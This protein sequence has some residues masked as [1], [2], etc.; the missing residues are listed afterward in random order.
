MEVSDRVMAVV[1]VFE[2]HVLKFTCGY[3][4]RSGSNFEEKQFFI[5]SWKVSA[6]C[7]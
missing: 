7:R 5:M 3:A 6:Y 4:K 2:E 1:L